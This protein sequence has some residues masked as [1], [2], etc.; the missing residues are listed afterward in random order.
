ML[1]AAVATLM[2][3]TGFADVAVAQEP[4]PQA[5]ARFKAR[6]LI[7]RV[8]GADIKAARTPFLKQSLARKLISTAAE[9][10]AGR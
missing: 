6:T 5:Q 1:L 8:F 4:V 9:T 3:T 2:L 7:R 10:R